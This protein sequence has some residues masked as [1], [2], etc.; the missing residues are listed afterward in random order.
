MALGKSTKEE[1]NLGGRPTKLTDELFEEICAWIAGGKSLR[2]FCRQRGKP[3]KSNILRWLASPENSRLRDQYAHARETAGHAHADEIVAMTELVERGEIDPQAAKVI[4]D[5][6]KWAAE[7][8]AAKVY[9][10]KQE[11]N[12]KSSDGS[13]TPVVQY[14]LPSNGRE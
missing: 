7:R 9:G 12:H 6:R 11:L 13:M 10:P 5:G 14:N 8:M 4:M 3:D 2:A 1:K